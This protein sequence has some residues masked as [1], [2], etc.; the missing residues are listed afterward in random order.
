MTTMTV[1]QAQRFLARHKRA[2]AGNS[3]PG[4]VPIEVAGKVIDASDYYESLRREG[5]RESSAAL[6]TDWAVE[7]YCYRLREARLALR[8]M[9]MEVTA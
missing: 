9:A 8:M 5:V 7:E 2:R 3:S 4:F 6:N 1:D